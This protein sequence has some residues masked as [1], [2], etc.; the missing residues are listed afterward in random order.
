MQQ[1]HQN[2]G[3]SAALRGLKNLKE[4]YKSKFL[5]IQQLKRKPIAHIND[6]A[7]EITQRVI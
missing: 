1:K 6:W 2:F 5:K 7:Y 4:I 3:R